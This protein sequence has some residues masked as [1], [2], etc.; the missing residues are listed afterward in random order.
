MLGKHTLNPKEKT[1]LQITFRTEGSPGPFRKIVTISTNIP[2]Q[3][4]VEVTIEGTVKEG[5][6]AK[7][8]VS[9][10]R[11]DL[12][13]VPRGTVKKQSFTIKNSGTLLLVIT[14]STQRTGELPGLTQARRPW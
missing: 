14:R 7:I 11:V 13:A 1:P 4:D 8:E 2:G 10:R 3:E 5:P 12:G 6:A 9:P